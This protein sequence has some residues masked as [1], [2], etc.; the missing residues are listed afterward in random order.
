MGGFTAL[1][2][3]MGCAVAGALGYARR[4][5]RGVAA[6]AVILSVANLGLAVAK[7]YR[8]GELA[9]MDPRGRATGLFWLFGL[10]SAAIVAFSFLG[11][12]FPQSQTS[13]RESK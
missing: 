8:L 1:A 9:A 7:W 3:L 5:T 12:F 11:L 4:L 13:P 2:L 10:S 6:V